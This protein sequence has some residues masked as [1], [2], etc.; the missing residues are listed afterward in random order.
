MTRVMTHTTACGGALILHHLTSRPLPPSLPAPHRPAPWPAPAPHRCRHSATSR[1]SG[2]A[3]ALLDVTA[4]NTASAAP[5]G[6]VASTADTTSSGPL[7]HGGPV[8]WGAG[9]E[10][11]HC[12]GAAPQGGS[13]VLGVRAARVWGSR[14][15]TASACGA[16]QPAALRWVR[17]SARAKPGARAARSTRAAPDGQRHA[18]GDVR[19]AGRRARGREHLLDRPV[20][21][22]W[23]RAARAVRVRAAA[24]CYRAPG[25]LQAAGSPPKGSHAPRPARPATTTTAP[26]SPA[27]P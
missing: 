2:S 24:C 20:P 4:S 16:Q 10:L 3:T 9:A 17:R 21:A 26:T 11:V 1:S 7:R 27:Q 13:K 19:R 18:A 22:G 15:V 8:G 12:S 14:A 23:R 6:S 5:R 25:R